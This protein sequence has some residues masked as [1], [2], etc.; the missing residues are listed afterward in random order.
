MRNEGSFSSK[1][2]TAR[3][4]A[5]SWGVAVGLALGFSVA[6]IAFVIVASG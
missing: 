2:A 3:W 5:F 6:W 1:P 4:I